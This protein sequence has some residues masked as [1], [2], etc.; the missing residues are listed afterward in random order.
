MAGLAG[1]ALFAAANARVVPPDLIIS[2][3]G[4]LAAVR[5]ETG[6]YLFSSLRHG[7]FARE[8]WLEHAGYR[9]D[10][11]AQWARDGGYGR[12]QR[13]GLRC[14]GVGCVLTRAGWRVV[15]SETRDALAEDCERADLVIALIPAKRACDGTGARVIDLFDLKAKGAHSITLGPAIKVQAVNDDRGRRPWVVR[16]VRKR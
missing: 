16:Q 14:D 10:E 2:A 5:A 4:D 15:L 11:A 12:L 8:N 13:D 1:I 3:T 7:R 9:A 6:G